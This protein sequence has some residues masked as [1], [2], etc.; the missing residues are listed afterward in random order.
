MTVVPMTRAH[1]DA[2][3]PFEREMFGT[4][5]WTASSYRWEIAETASRV[6]LATEGPDGELL[7]WGGVLVAA[8]KAQIMTVGVVPTAR[9]RGIAT[10]LVRALLD[11]ARARGAVEAFLEVRVDNAAAQRLYEREGFTEIGRR[12]GYYDHGRVDALGMYRAL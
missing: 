12:C 10:Q 5:A 2:L 11:A 8:D 9:R 6:Y 4:E 1:I 3:M 7:A